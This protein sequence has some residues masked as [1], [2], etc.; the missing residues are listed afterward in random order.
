M[1]YNWIFPKQLPKNI[2]FIC[3]KN[4]QLKNY[5]NKKLIKH[6]RSSSSCVNKCL[7]KSAVKYKSKCFFRIKKIPAKKY[8]FFKV[9]GN[10]SLIKKISFLV[11]LFW[12]LIAIKN[13]PKIKTRTSFPQTSLVLPLVPTKKPPRSP[14]QQKIGLFT[15]N[16]HLGF[17]KNHRRAFSTKK[18]CPFGWAALKPL[19]PPKGQKS[20]DGTSPSPTFL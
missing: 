4:A 8:L 15:K 9:T 13:I 5:D 17:T 14:L 19:S 20:Q 1:Y 7:F 10:F 2:I 11:L 12:K 3:R 16:Y 18:T 6:F